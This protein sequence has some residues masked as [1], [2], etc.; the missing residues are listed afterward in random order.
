MESTHCKYYQYGFCK[1]GDFCRKQHVKE[2]CSQKFCRE[3][4]CLKRHPKPCRNFKSALS[5]KFGDTCAYKHVTLNTHSD[6]DD[7]KAN[8]KSL[9]GTIT[10][11]SQ[12]I[13]Y[14]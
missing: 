6:I 8:I 1:F 11:M 10:D 4:M 14:L 9:E 2:V 13:I 7:L 5:C 3:K 12:K